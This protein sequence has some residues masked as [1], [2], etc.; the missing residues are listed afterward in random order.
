MVGESVT[1]GTVVR[2]LKAEGDRV[3]RDEPLVEVETEKVD[4]EIPS[5]WAGVLQRVVA[6]GLLREEWDI[7]THQGGAAFSACSE[8]ENGL[9]K[10]HEAAAD[11][12]VGR[13]P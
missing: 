3:A 1:E 6:R 9:T 5:P 12:N 11:T 13:Q 2:W 8:C 4:V 10:S 7:H